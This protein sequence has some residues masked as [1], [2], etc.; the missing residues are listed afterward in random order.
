MK[1]KRTK[2]EQ[3]KRKKAAWQTRKDDKRI[4]AEV[5][6]RMARFPLVMV[7]SEATERACG[8]CTACCTAIAVHEL[9]KPMW[10]DCQH[11]RQGQGCAV[12]EQRPD[13]CKSYWCMWQS[14]MLK[15]EENRPDKLGVIFDFRCEG[16]EDAISAWELWE[17]ASDQP[18][19]KKIIDGILKQMNLKVIIIIR[20]YKSPKRR[21]I[22]SAHL[23]SG[24]T[25]KEIN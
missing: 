8:G 13:S 5:E 21:I 7:K 9:D 3:H 18:Q 10:T 15:G 23:L 17:G 16:T 12:Y 20:R 19:V 22:G 14:G 6:R 4:D 2:R 1:D 24:M 25:L 11:Q